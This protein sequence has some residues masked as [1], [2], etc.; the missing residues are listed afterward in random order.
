MYDLWEGMRK[1]DKDLA[2]EILEPTFTFMRAQTDKARLEM[3]EL[4]QY[5][6]YRERD[7]GKALLSALM[8]FAMD[9]RLPAAEITLMTPLERNCSKHT[10]SVNDIY[11]FDKE[12]RT[13]QMGHAESAA[14]CS[15]VS[16]LATETGLS[17]EACKR[18]LWAM[19]REWEAVHDELVESVQNTGR[20]SEAAKLYMKGLEYQMSGNELW[21]HSTLRYSK[22]E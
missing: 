16:V 17:V 21:S 22:V 12:L 14:V 6:E 1:H 8:R 7:V 3:R 10:S 15:A 4:G 11:S 5:L 20:I 9:I 2:D 13:S 18:V 19:V